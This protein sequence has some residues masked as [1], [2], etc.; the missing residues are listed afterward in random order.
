MKLLP[1]MSPAA[2]LDHQAR[3]GRARGWSVEWFGRG[4]RHGLLGLGSRRRPGVPR[5]YLSAGIHGDEPAGPPAVGELMEALE[6]P[7]PVDWVVCPLLNPA[8]WEKGSRENGYGA[9]LNRDYRLAT[10]PETAAHRAFIRRE[11]PWDLYLSLHEDWESS[12]FYLYEL[13]NS[14]HCSL[15]G[16]ILKAVCGVLPAAAE[17]L[18]DRHLV[19]EAGCIRHPCAPDEP[20]NWP[21]AIFCLKQFPMLSYTFETP[22]RMPL[23]VRVQALVLA[24]RAAV[25]AFCEGWMGSG[26]ILGEGR[27]WAR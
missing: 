4:G 1:H 20:L 19:E 21:E 14:R 15:C 11:G 3:L 27:L 16:P 6:H 22:S 9:D 7:Y 5:I 26:G 13:N 17:R 10:Q 8:G 23:E 24:A 18:I 25:E 12:G 2:W